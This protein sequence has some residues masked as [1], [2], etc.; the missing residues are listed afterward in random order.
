M[1]TR[2]SALTYR[3]QRA[4][5]TSKWP[6]LQKFSGLLKDKAII[7]AVMRASRPL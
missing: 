1:I 3:L 5:I 7:N 2:M 6:I 4:D